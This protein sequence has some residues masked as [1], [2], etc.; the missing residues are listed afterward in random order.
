[1]ELEF[2]W[3]IIKKN[4]HIKFHENSYSESRVV[5]F[6]WIH[7]YNKTDGQLFQFYELTKN[8]PLIVDNGTVSKIYKDFEA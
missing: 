6:G 8:V 3:Q 2:S 1:M 4:T 7:R 5:P